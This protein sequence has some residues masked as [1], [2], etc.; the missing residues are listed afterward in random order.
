MQFAQYSILRK[1]STQ[2]TTAKEMGLSIARIKNVVDSGDSQS[3]VMYLN[4]DVPYG[5]LQRI[6]MDEVFATV[7]ANVLT[8]YTYGTS[9]TVNAYNNVGELADKTISVDN[10]EYLLANAAGDVIVMYSNPAVV[11][12]SGKL[13]L[14]PSVTLATIL[15]ELNLG[16]P[17]NTATFGASAATTQ[18]S[19][20][21]QALAADVYSLQA[22]EDDEWVTKK[23]KTSISGSSQACN[24]TALTG[25]A[26]ID[27]PSDIRLLRTRNGVDLVIATGT[28]SF[29]P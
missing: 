1:G 15:L 2:Y 7:T 4:N 20:V 17:I 21:A 9:I 13:N 22:L 6:L 8:G 14:N 10:I 28:Y 18:A 16:V 3:T 26:A 12:G 5:Q 29:T 25:G 27:N 19:T 11:G 24:F 23:T